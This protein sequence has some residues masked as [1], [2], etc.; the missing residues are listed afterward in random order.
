MSGLLL[1]PLPHSLV[2]ILTKSYK[3]NLE[4]QLYTKFFII[5]IFCFQ[6]LHVEKI[7][8]QKDFSSHFYFH[9][10]SN[11]IQQEWS[12]QKHKKERKKNTELLIFDASIKRKTNALLKLGVFNDY[13]SK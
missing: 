2:I 5:K 10:L 4:Q 11:G 12:L 13:L 3:S 1:R 6:F 9:W 8:Y 7:E